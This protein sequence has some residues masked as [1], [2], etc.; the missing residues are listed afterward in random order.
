MVLS[1]KLSNKPDVLTA[2]EYRQYA[3]DKNLDISVFDLGANTDWFNEIS[4]TGVTQ[5][6]DLSLSGGGAATNYRVSVS[7]LDQQGV[8]MDNYQKRINTRFSINQKALKEKFDLT[9]SGG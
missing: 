7:Y 6:H 1:D 2:D 5:N 3:R 9:L 8:M 4:R